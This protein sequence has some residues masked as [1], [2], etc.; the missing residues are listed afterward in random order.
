MRF[1]GD[2]RPHSEE[3]VLDIRSYRM[4]KVLREV[5]VF[6]GEEFVKSLWMIDIERRYQSGFC[7]GSFVLQ[8]LRIGSEHGL[9][10]RPYT[11]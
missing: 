2:D 5:L 1:T 4:L 11:Y 10:D 7:L 9:A 3:E 8:P 6:A